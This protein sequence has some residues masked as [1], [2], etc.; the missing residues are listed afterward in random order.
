MENKGSTNFVDVIE[1][2][3]GRPLLKKELINKP[4]GYSELEN[5]SIALNNFNKEYKLPLKN[6]TDL[7]PSISPRLKIA[8]NLGFNYVSRIHEFSEYKGMF[9]GELKKYLLYCHGLV[10]EDPLAYLLDYFR[11]GCANSPYAI[12][13]IP[14]INS[15]LLEYSVISELIRSNVIFPV[16][17]PQRYE[18]EV[19]YPED[20]L[21]AEL[22]NRLN[23]SK[24]NIP[25]LARFIFREQFRKLNFENNV[26]LFYPG[27]E[28][29]DVL[30]E[31]MKIQ[32]EKF[33]SNQMAA[34]FGTSV[35]G[36]ISL[37]NLEQIS[38]EDISYMRQQEELFSEWRGFL[39]VTF[40]ELYRNSAEY[41]DLKD[42]FLNESRYQ[43]HNLEKRMSSK[44]SNA[45]ANVSIKNTGRNIS[46]GAISGAVSG[47]LSGDLETTIFMTLL[48]GMISGGAQPSLDAI[49]NLVQ[50][51]SRKKEIKVVR[52]HFLALDLPSSR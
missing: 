23:D 26:D 1:D 34:Y 10:I 40:K 19:P 5:L 52:N 46:V 31:I 21:L 7:R 8:D 13:R 35:I 30:K 38:I 4:V 15:L 9:I 45:F 41:T 11:P 3:I 16:S 44:L 27:V 51:K 32:E 24:Y 42:E 2:A 14:V 49:I 37:L 48:T 39:N 25:E 29:I 43:F 17:E 50:K 47:M 6:E 33:T 18:N 22:S 20:D 12:A 36:S 28:Y